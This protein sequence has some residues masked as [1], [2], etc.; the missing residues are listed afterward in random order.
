MK[1]L[2]FMNL[3]N[4]AGIFLGIMVILLIGAGAV[5]SGSL[6]ERSISIVA[7]MRQNFSIP[8]TE[9]IT[10]SLASV[11]NGAAEARKYPFKGAVIKLDENEL[12]NLSDDE[13]AG[14]MAHELAHIR[15]YSWMNWASLVFY[16]LRYEFSDSFKREVERG[17]DTR[18]IQIGFGRELGAF[19]NY[20]LR[21]ANDADKKIIE[22]YYLSSEEIRNFTR[23]VS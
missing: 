5:R 17:T 7:E 19:R 18:A 22:K 14:L 21:T 6:E 15:V 8:E 10:I 1:Y 20:R 16:G 12:S 4:L 13:L 9:K 3:F 2:Q 11:E 23:G